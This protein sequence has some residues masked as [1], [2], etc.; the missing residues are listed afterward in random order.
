MRWNLSFSTQK[1]NWG[2]LFLALFSR[3]GAPLTKWGGRARVFLF[4]WQACL[5]I[6][7]S[8]QVMCGPCNFPCVTPMGPIVK[9]VH[10]F[11]DG[12]NYWE[13]KTSKWTGISRWVK[14]KV[15]SFRKGLW[16]YAYTLKFNYTLA[17]WALVYMQRKW[18]AVNCPKRLRL[19]W[20]KN[21]EKGRRSN[22]GQG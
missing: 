19:F 16:V 6:E 13:P 10:F 2:I 15:C 20:W 9:S 4:K 8:S 7:Y 1:F 12:A 22:E 17:Q 14:Q 21:D 11:L 5:P 3:R 18:P